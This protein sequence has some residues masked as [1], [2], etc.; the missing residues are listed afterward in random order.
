M[1]QYYLVLLV[2]SL[3]LFLHTTTLLTVSLLGELLLL[4]PTN[5]LAL[6]ALSVRIFLVYYFVV[7]K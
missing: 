6:L 2:F 5:L 1:K 3:F 4:I 7:Q